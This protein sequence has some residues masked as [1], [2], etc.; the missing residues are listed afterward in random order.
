M[1]T[2]RARILEMVKDG[3]ISI[4]QADELLEALENAVP[5]TPAHISPLEPNQFGPE[6]KPRVEV[7][8]SRSTNGGKYN[9]EQMIELGKFGVSAKFIRELAEVGLTDLSFDEVIEL[10]KFGISP[11]FVLEMRQLSEEFDLGELN[12]ERIIELGKF[13]VSATFVREMIETQMID[14]TLPASQWAHHEPDDER[15]E[16]L[17]ARLEEARAKLSQVKTEHERKTLEG[18]I[19]KV[20]EKLELKLS[21][22][23]TEHERETLEKITEKVVEEIERKLSQVDSTQP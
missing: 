21:Q 19:D 18:I 13:G 10:G 20:T 1:K 15:R 23:K 7:R 5:N 11:K 22:V 17:Q 12:L 8:I 16:K 6:H 2:G 14:F 9:F 4:E 3:K